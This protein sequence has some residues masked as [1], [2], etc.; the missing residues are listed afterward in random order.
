MALVAQ[1]IYLLG[2][3]SIFRNKF[4]VISKESE[5]AG[6]FLASPGRLKVLDIFHIFIRRLDTSTRYLKSK[7]VDLL[8]KKMVSV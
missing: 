1:A 5:E 2:Q 8:L 6:Q 4:K 7:K 3:P